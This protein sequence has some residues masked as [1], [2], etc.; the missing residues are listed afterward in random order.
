AHGGKGPSADAAGLLAEAAVTMPQLLGS[1]AEEEKGSRHKK[2]EGVKEIRQTLDLITDPD[3]VA[4][5]VR[6]ADRECARKGHP[7]LLEGVANQRADK[8]ELNAQIGLELLRVD[9]EKYRGDAE[10][11]LTKLGTAETPG[12]QALRTALGKPLPAKKKDENPAPSPAAT[13]EA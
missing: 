5:V 10:G 3:L 11:L 12:A 7:T 8:D 6:P 9:R 4:E 13:A 1:T 2:D